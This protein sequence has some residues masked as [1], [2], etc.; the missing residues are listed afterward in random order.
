VRAALRLSYAR[1]EPQGIAAS[2][3]NLAIYLGRLG[4]DRAGQRAHRLAAV[5]IWRLSGMTHNLAESVRT[6]AV[7]LRGEDSATRLPAT[8]A[9]V[10]ATAELT[11]GVRLD[12]LLAALQPDP[13]AVEDALTEILRAATELPPKTTS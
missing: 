7:E 9:Q 2:H 8:A 6:L 10:V 4:G 13:R 12:T 3:R 1:P 5:L 11:E